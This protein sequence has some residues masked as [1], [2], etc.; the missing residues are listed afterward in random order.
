MYMHESIKYSLVIR[1]E[2]SKFLKYITL[3]APFLKQNQ[4]ENLFKHS[5]YRAL[6]T[7]QISNCMNRIP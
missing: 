4:T 7:G 2:L 3:T 1:I 5:F 6:T